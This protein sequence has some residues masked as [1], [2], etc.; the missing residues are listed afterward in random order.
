MFKRERISVGRS[1]IADLCLTDVAVSGTHFEVEAQEGG[2]LLR[3][4][5]STNGTYVHEENKTPIYLRREEAPLQGT[6]V[7][8]VGQQVDPANPWLIQYQ[9]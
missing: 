9:H 4:L 2:Y 5:E 1:R 6:G 7:I 8:S 3:D